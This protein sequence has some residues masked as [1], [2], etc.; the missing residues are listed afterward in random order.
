MFAKWPI[1][2]EK[3]LSHAGCALYSLGAA[4]PTRVRAAH[5]L[6][7]RFGEWLLVL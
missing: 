7:R 4:T 1:L 3:S 6:R 2:A 5:I